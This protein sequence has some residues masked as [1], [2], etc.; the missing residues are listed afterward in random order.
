M[1][2]PGNAPNGDQNDGSSTTSGPGERR[3]QYVVRYPDPQAPATPPDRREDDELQGDGADPS[4]HLDAGE[5]QTVEPAGAENV[6]RPADS[7]AEEIE[8]AGDES[9][10][11]AVP[12]ATEAEAA[13]LESAA[14]ASQRPPSATQAVVPIVVGTRP[15][16]IKLVPIIL[17]LRESEYYPSDRG[18][19]G[20]HH[21]MVPNLR[22]GRHHRRRYAVGRY[23]ARAQR[24]GH[25]RD[26][27][28]RGLLRASG[29]EVPDGPAS[30]RADC[31]RQLPAAVLVHGDTSSAMSARRSPH[32]TC[33]YP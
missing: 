1:A 9:I 32:F 27:A 2:F 18:L 12:A 3:G 31:A 24:A 22:A 28:V 16:A 29:S 17:A 30:S 21:R 15:E 10:S 8:L 6:P 11:S 7:V 13:Q 23:A 20:Q 5:A 33:A 25:L 14:K 26:A 4:E 19:H